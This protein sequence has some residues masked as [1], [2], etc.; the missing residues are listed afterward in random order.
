MPL[1]YGFLTGS[2]QPPTAIIATTTELLHESPNSHLAVDL[3]PQAV[4][5]VTKDAHSSHVTAQAIV[6]LPCDSSAQLCLQG[7]GDKLHVDANVFNDWLDTIML[8][9]SSKGDSNDHLG[10]HAD[11]AIRDNPTLP[12]SHGRQPLCNDLQPSSNQVSC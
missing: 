6:N 11:G 10:S 9:Y 12:S 4:G 5:E 7:T 8:D 2:S 3:N 1:K